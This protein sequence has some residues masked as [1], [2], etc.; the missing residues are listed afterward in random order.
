MKSEKKTSD[1]EEEEVEEGD[2]EEKKRNKR[3]DWSR[4]QQTGGAII[5]HLSSDWVMIP[6]RDKRAGWVVFV[7]VVVV[8][9]LASIL[10]VNGA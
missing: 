9:C 3:P 2:L 6:Q 4:L 1:E 10:S 5:R 7:P 8:P